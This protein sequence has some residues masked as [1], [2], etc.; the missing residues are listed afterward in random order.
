ML[1][2][3]PATEEAAA[4]AIAL[5]STLLMYQRGKA[6]YIDGFL[7]GFSLPTQEDNQ[8]L[9]MI[10]KLTHMVLVDFALHLHSRC[11]MLLLERPSHG[12][13]QVYHTREEEGKRE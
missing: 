12:P 4:I 2:T 3:H 7:V 13:I 10:N 1:L 6:N 11:V 8:A 9:W 5:I